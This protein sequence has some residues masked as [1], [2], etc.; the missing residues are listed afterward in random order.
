MSIKPTI[1]KAGPVLKFLPD[2]LTLLNLFSGFMALWLILHGQEGPAIFCIWLALLWD[3][4]DGNVARIFG[5]ATEFGRELDS[6][7]DMVS[8]GVAPAM[9]AAN[10]LGH[11]T[12]S[13]PFLLVFVYLGAVAYRL[14]RFNIRPVI[15]GEF[16]GLP[17]PA[18]AITLSAL[19]LASIKN[20]W[21]NLTCFAPLLL[22]FLFIG[23]F[24]MVSRVPYPKVSTL[25][26]ER[27]QSLLWLEIGI[28]LL[29]LISLNAETALAGS[30]LFFVLAG[31][32]YCMTPGRIFSWKTAVPPAE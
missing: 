12:D 32:L 18:A 14:A 26:F 17:A 30:C 1:R 7:S 15:K 22:V 4:L 19:V 10:L 9:L 20:G 31:P 11:L 8:F 6:L 2:F 16:E 23:A 29:G 5:I 3:S 13:W 28:C 27:W 24:L 21:V 25:P